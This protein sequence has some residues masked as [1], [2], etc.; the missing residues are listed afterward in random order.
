MRDHPSK[1]NAAFSSQHGDGKDLGKAERM[2]LRNEIARTLL[3]EEDSDV[4]AQLGE[5][6]KSQH[7]AEME[8]WNLILEGVS[9]ASDVSQW[10]FIIFALGLLA[11]VLLLGLEIPSSTPCTPSSRPSVLMPVAALLS[12]REML[13]REML[14]MGF[15]LRKSIL[16]PESTS[17]LTLLRSVHWWPGDHSKT[18]DWTQWDAD[19]FSSG[20][21][22][23]FL[24][25]AGEI[26]A[27]HRCERCRGRLNF[28]PIFQIN[29]YREKTKQDPC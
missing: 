22:G 23:P 3:S 4:A 19:G 26:S 28:L 20:V 16:S 10:V 24:A 5:R 6:A 29:R 2:N 11:Y 27:S 25:Y 17:L 14:T 13:T 12:S 1:V 7:D 8:E 18:K 9:L 15:S 21:A